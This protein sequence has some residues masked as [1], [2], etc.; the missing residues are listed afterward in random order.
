M[1]DDQVCKGITA[2]ASFDII[3]S[4]PGF[5]KSSLLGS[6]IPEHELGAF[7][8]KIMRV[9]EPNGKDFD[10]VGRLRSAVTVHLHP[11][12]WADTQWVHDCRKEA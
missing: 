12:F 6:D 10:E 11:T 8:A 7:L 2:M 9:R 5:N 1:T 3:G 4:E